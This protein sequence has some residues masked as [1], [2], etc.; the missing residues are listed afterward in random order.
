MHII[1]YLFVYL[2]ILP[3]FVIWPLLILY[4]FYLKK[5]G[6]ENDFITRQVK[7]LRCFAAAR[8]PGLGS[9]TLI[10]ELEREHKV[11]RVE[12]ERGIRWKAH[13]L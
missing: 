5:K 2:F 10:R 4:R 8:F 11:I 6:I 7:T 1:R 12:E 13:P 3:K 9:L